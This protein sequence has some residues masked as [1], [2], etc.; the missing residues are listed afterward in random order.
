MVNPLEGKTLGN[1]HLMEKIGQGG[2]TTVYKALDLSRSQVVALKILSP[3]IAQDENFRTRFQLEVNL[4][5]DMRHSNIVPILDYGEQD[6]YS[7]IVM[8]YYAAGT[9]QDRMR[10]NPLDPFEIGR[11]MRQLTSALEFAHTK[12]VVHRDVKASNILIHDSGQ[13][14][15]SDFGFARVSD[16]SMSLTGSALIGTPAYMSPEQC[17]GAP[18]DARSDQYSLGIVLYQLFTGTVP[19]EGDTP[20]AVA[21]QHIN[22]PLPRPRRFNPDLPDAIESVLLKALS[23]DPDHR[24]PHIDTMNEAFQDGLRQS[25]DGFGQFVPRMNRF[26]L[27]TWIMEKTPLGSSLQTISHWW[28][29]RRPAMVMVALLALMLPTAGYAVASVFDSQPVERVELVSGQDA[30]LQAT[31][32]ALSTSI[33]MEAGQ[34]A[35]PALIEA[36]VAGTLAAQARAGSGR[37][38]ATPGDSGTL[39]VALEPT[40]ESGIVADAG[41]EQA[42][43]EGDGSDG[44]PGPSATPDASATPAPG[45]TSTPAPSSTP[46]PP[47]EPPAPTSTPVPPTAPP[48]PTNNPKPTKTPKPPNPNACND[49]PDHPNY[50]PP[51]P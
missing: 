25:V 18:I 24:Y 20:M 9:L 5:R 14:L 51:E 28:R 17:K 32:D 45:E 44:G 43:S 7:F 26:D 41:T 33:A 21:V 6:M 27:A 31:I 15:L 23:K 47:T 49:N 22:E 4:L 34:G 48:A 10:K 40:S 12:G 39:A 29:E 2:M 30:E 36:A 19:F 8:P 16:L 46:V 1:Y 35:D 37:P 3:Y 38:T 11:L 50:C 42:T 13:A